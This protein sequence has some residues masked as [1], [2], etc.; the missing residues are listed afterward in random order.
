MN[1]L[2][3]IGTPTA[4][5]RTPSSLASTTTATGVQNR[6][7]ASGLLFYSKFTIFESAHYLAYNLYK[8]MKA[9][10]HIE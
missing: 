3:R 2:V 5:T 7:I 4:E 1:F 10:N 6:F 8:A 9:N